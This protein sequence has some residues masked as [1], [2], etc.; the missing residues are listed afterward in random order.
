MIR[1]ISLRENGQ[2]AGPPHRGGPCSHPANFICWGPVHKRHSLAVKSIAA[3]ACATG[4]AAGPPRRG[5]PCSHPANFICRGPAHKRR[6][7]QFAQR[8]HRGLCR[9]RRPQN[10]EAPLGRQFLMQSKEI[11]RGSP[12]GDVCLPTFVGVSLRET[13][14]PFVIVKLYGPCFWPANTLDAALRENCLPGTMVFC[15]STPKNAGPFP[16]NCFVPLQAAGPRGQSHLPPTGSGRPQRRP[17]FFAASQRPPSRS[18]SPPPSSRKVL[19]SRKIETVLVDIYNPL[20][21]RRRRLL[22]DKGFF[23]MTQVERIAAEEIAD[24]L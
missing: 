1:G 6:I 21:F 13:A 2:A 4:Q 10:C 15:I 14:D 23:V 19:I 22:N 8:P 20:R 3:I 5:G 12:Y 17:P 11:S 24:C 18:C 9:L 16:L 7:G